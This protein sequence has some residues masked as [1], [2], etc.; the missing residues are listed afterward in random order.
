MS[1]DLEPTMAS[2]RM[3]LAAASSVV[4]RPWSVWVRDPLHPSETAARK[5]TT[6][7]LRAEAP[8]GRVTGSMRRRREGFSLRSR[9]RTGPMP[10]RRP[11]ATP[12]TMMV[13]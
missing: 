1:E 6:P 9:A 7:R 11:Q 12:S 2:Q 5:T 3:L 13:T 4:V 10:T 8:R